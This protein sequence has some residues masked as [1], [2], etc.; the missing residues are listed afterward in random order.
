M[1]STFIQCKFHVDIHE[2]PWRGD[3]NDSGV[4]K[5]GNLY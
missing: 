3:S 2:V 5:T 4:V 1:G